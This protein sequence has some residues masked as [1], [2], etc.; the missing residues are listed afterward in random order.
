M[1]QFF[2][3]CSSVHLTSPKNEPVAVAPCRRKH[4]APLILLSLQMQEEGAILSREVLWWFFLCEVTT[5]KD[6]WSKQGKW[7]QEQNPLSTGIY[8]YSFQT[9]HF[10]SSIH[11][12]EPLHALSPESFKKNIM[13]LFLAKHPLLC[14]LQQK[15]LLLLLFRDGSD[16]VNENIPRRLGGYLNTWS[17]VSDAVRSSDTAS[18]GEVHQALRVQNL[19]CFQFALLASCCVWRCDL[20]ASCPS[21]PATMDSPSRP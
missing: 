14:L 12:S 19:P 3:I 17:P 15:L 21:S 18:L 11:S 10:L 6:L 16:G 8:I 20:L 5:S 7:M 9:S 1:K 2:V 4:Q 13:C